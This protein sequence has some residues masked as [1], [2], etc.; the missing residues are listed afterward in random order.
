ME[1]IKG[2]I[3]AVTDPKEYKGEMQLGF[4][5]D[6]RWFNI[7][8]QKEVLEGMKEETFVKG[9]ELEFNFNDGEITNFKVLRTAEETGAEKDDDMVNFEKLLDAAHKL[10][11]TFSIKTEMLAVDLEK[12]YALFKAQVI[13]G[14]YEL[15]DLKIMGTIFEAHGDAT[16]ENVSG[17][18]IKP[19][20]IR[21]AETRAI[22]RANRW[23]NNNATFSEEEKK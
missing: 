4:K 23:Y 6:E 19:H 18:Y 10:K 17:D 13:T 11:K 8:N 9:N 5:I 7:K 21:M 12:K 20:F 14:E 16:E 15:K 22:C 3:K 1:I 2:I